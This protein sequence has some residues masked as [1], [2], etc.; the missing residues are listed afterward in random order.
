MPA[1]LI[2]IKNLL[3]TKIPKKFIKKS[4]LYAMKIIKNL[5]IPAFYLQTIQS[6]EIN[7]LF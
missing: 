2:M 5:Q 7:N 4:N 1:L 6:L 3:G